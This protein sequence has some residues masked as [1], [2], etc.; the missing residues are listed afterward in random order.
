VTG[1]RSDPG[2]AD[3]RARARAD[4][5]AAPPGDGDRQRDRDRDERRGRGRGPGGRRHARGVATRPGPAGPRSRP[6]DELRSSGGR[7]TIRH[8]GLGV[9]G[10]SRAP[11]PSCGR[12]PDLPSRSPRVRAREPAGRR[13]GRPERAAASA[14]LAGSPRDRGDTR[15][16]RRRGRRRAR[17]RARRRVRDQG[18]GREVEALAAPVEDQ[19]VDPNS[20]GGY[21]TKANGQNF[22]DKLAASQQSQTITSRAEAD[23]YLLETKHAL[24]NRHDGQ[25][26]S[27]T[28]SPPAPAEEGYGG[29]LQV[30]VYQVIAEVFGVEI[31]EIALRQ[32]QQEYFHSFCFVETSEK[33]T[34]KNGRQEIRVTSQQLRL[35]G[36]LQEI[37]EMQQLVATLLETEPIGPSQNK[38]NKRPDLDIATTIVGRPYSFTEDVETLQ[39]KV[40]EALYQPNF[41][42]G[43]IFNPNHIDTEKQTKLHHIF[44]V[45][46]EMY[47][48]NAFQF[49]EKALAAMKNN[50]SEIAQQAVD[51]LDTLWSYTKNSLSEHLYQQKPELLAAFKPHGLV[52]SLI[53]LWQFMPKKADDLVSL[54]SALNKKLRLGNQQEAPSDTKSY[55]GLVEDAF[56]DRAAGIGNYSHLFNFMERVNSVGQCGLG[57]FLSAKTFGSQFSVPSV[58]IAGNVESL[59]NHFMQ[60]NS[61]SELRVMK[62]DITNYILLTQVD[63]HRLKTP[64]MVPPS[65]FDE[66]GVFLGY[67]SE[68]LGEA[69][70]PCDLPLADEPL[71]GTAGAAMTL[72]EYNAYKQ[73]LNKALQTKQQDQ[74][75]RSLLQNAEGK[76]SKEEANQL[77]TYVFNLLTQLLESQ[78]LQN[79]VSGSPQIDASNVNSVQQDLSQ[80]TTDTEEINADSLISQIMIARNPIAMLKNLI[81][82]LEVKLGLYN[83]SNP[84]QQELLAAQL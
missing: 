4:P 28:F 84:W 77:I 51:D 32:F 67:F 33:V 59:T 42:D 62:Q 24:M 68:E 26:I 76:L 70:G 21:T 27:V 49:A 81:A 73:S 44:E 79:F 82:D 15:H 83:S 74:A 37:R 31:A 65:Y 2:L 30:G 3:R 56:V 36:G 14:S 53:Y 43:W 54:W 47:I 75:T 57:S 1:V 13:A 17:R 34:K 72:A 20:N 38:F 8:L 35:G 23:H 64:F 46:F 45:F 71:R 80:K 52:G 19:E 16:R 66:D 63:G 60:K 12:G 11:R 55:V 29:S 5:H 58:Q 9:L 39:Q 78:T 48:S 22:V 7:A 25:Y 61:L 10:G 69:I 6:V 40:I 41:S 18:L 50:Q